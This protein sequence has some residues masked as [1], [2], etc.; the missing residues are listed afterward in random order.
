[1]TECTCNQRPF[2]P[3]KVRAKAGEFERIITFR[4]GFVC[5]KYL[6]NPNDMSGHGRHGMDMLFLLVGERGVIQFLTFIGWQPDW[7]YRVGKE[8]WTMPADL[9]YHAREPQ[10][11]G[12]LAQDDCPWLGDKCYYD[13]SGLRANDVFQVFVRDG[14]EAL[15]AFLESEYKERFA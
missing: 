14:E 7:E 5:E 2:F 15:W 13:G 3:A 10:Y 8:S 4:Q 1:M 6:A 12:Q 9:G 11:E